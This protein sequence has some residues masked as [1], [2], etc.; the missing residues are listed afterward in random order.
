MTALAAPEAES[1]W[2]ARWLTRTF[3]VTG[4]LLL[5]SLVVLEWPLD[6]VGD[7][8]QFL[9]L[10]VAALGVP[11]VPPGLAR[12]ERSAA[13]AARKIRAW[14]KAK[15][16]QARRRWNRMR[17][18]T[19]VVAMSGRATATGSGSVTA[20][21]I[22]GKVDRST[23]GNREWLAFLNNEVDSL[24]ATL[25]QLQESSGAERE[26]L[27]ARLVEQRRELQAHTL[28]VTRGGW[29]YIL[30]GAACTAL[31]IGLSLVA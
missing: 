23:V 14:V 24:W 19:N 25:R 30:A 31:G 15:V 13:A 16:A 28:A 5:A 20:T 26:H 8:L 22:R 3:A 27:D 4:V 6:K 10:C 12:A 1:R 18:S 2:L 11:V 29:Q 17:G 7:A 9:G 21:V